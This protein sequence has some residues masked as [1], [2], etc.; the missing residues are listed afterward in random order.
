MDC[1]RCSL[2]PRIKRERVAGKSA[3]PLLFL[4]S[5][6]F[7]E[8]AAFIPCGPLRIAGNQI[9]TQ[10]HEAR[11]FGALIKLESWLFHILPVF[12]VSLQIPFLAEI[13]KIENWKW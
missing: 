9:S 7:S 12:G 4:F 13:Q 10:K 5:V 11:I 1:H 6:P 8:E 2:F 3:G